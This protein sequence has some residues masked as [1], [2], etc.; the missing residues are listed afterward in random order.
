[1]SFASLVEL[2]QEDA[3]HRVRDTTRGAQ[4]NIINRWLLP[5]FGQLPVDKIDAVTIRK[6]QNELFS[7]TNPK[8]GKPYAPHTSAP[9]TAGFLP[10]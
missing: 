6:W 4:D 3:D 2:Y 9:S 10:L 1:M 8:T 5:Y 7:K